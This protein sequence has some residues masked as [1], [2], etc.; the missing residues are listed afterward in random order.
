MRMNSFRHFHPVLLVLL[1]FSCSALAIIN[2]VANLYSALQASSNKNVG[3]LAATNYIT[4]T[5]EF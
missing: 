3:F 4:G 2:S 5:C 1:L